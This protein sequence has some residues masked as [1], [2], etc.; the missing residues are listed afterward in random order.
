MLPGYVSGFYTFDD[1]H[2]D[3]V[4]LSQYCNTRLIHASATGIDL[5]SQEVL[6]HNRPPLPYDVL[7]INVG[8]APITSEIPGASQY[9]IPVKP[10][11]TFA[12][13]FKTMLEEALQGS[14][15]EYRIIIVGGGPAGVELACAVKY[16]LTE[17]RKKVGI[18]APVI[19]SLVSRGNIL[20]ELAPYARRTF[21]LLLKERNIEVYE[22][23]KGVVSVDAASL[24]LDDG[25][26]V[27][28]NTCLWCTQAGA[29]GWL[30][31]SAL[32]TDDRGFLRINEYLQADC[33]PDNVFGAGDCTAFVTHPR[34]KAGVYAVR[35]VGRNQLKTLEEDW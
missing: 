4:R 10:I 25:R 14:S 21:L 1:C 17:E 9:T 20:A 13:K 31:E 27:L 33:G 6:L 8:I 28:F 12:L 16:R 22:T 7:S 15:L 26:I 34:P 35:A 5:S 19:V 32:P 18:D 29:A 2:I 30:A 11:S 23:Q 3:L 24:T